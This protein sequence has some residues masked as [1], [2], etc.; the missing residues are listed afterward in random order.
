[1]RDRVR[2]ALMKTQR[3]KAIRPG[4]GARVNLRVS[5]E[6]LAR[7]QR[8]VEKSH[9]RTLTALICQLMGRECERLGVK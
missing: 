8:A 1:M 9:L 3:L 7:W 4:R 6:E 2:L 5:E